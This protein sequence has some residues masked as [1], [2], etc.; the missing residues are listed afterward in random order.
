MPY[1][2]LSLVHPK[3]GH[4]EE[5][6]HL[7][8]ELERFAASW[9]GYVCGWV[10]CNADGLGELGRLT[11]WRSEHDADSAAGELHPMSLRSRLDFLI[12]EERHQETAYEALDVA[13]KAAV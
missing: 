11:V 9:P 10:L 4:E 3:P 2:R 7:L 6:Q 13:G 5:V 1:I 12:D 8:S